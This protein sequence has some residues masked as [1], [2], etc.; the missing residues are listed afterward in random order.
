MNLTRQYF[1]S[2]PSHL[3][4]PSTVFR[5][6]EYSWSPAWIKRCVPKDEH[7][8]TGVGANVVSMEHALLVEIWEIFPYF[9]TIVTRSDTCKIEA[10][11]CWISHRS[12]RWLPFIAN[13]YTW[14]SSV[15]INQEGVFVSED[16]SIH[17]K[18]E[19]GGLRESSRAI[20]FS[21]LPPR[22][23]WM[24]MM[25]FSRAQTTKPSNAAWMAMMEAS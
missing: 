24:V 7:R 3:R 2:I 14:P 18:I 21:S 20:C 6:A 17:K 15:P 19:S 22:A 5:S 8:T 25:H 11:G 23:W 4:S 1:V 10:T 9:P 16:G 12:F 13:W